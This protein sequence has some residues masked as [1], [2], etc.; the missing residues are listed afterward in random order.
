[1]DSKFI[2]FWKNYFFEENRRSTLRAVCFQWLSTKFF[3]YYIDTS[4]FYKS[5]ERERIATF[6]AN[7]FALFLARVP[8]FV[9]TSWDLDNS[10]GLVWNQSF[11]QQN[12]AHALTNAQSFPSNSE[13]ERH[14]ILAQWQISLS[15]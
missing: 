7:S 11:S 1:M 8:D 13:V 15:P 4:L 3:K 10:W 14:S 5:I 12:C 6:S 2:V 9:Q